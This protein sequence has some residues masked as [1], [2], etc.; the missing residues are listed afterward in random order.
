[1]YAAIQAGNYEVAKDMEA[2]KAEAMKETERN[3]RV[4]FALQEIAN[5]EHIVAT[6]QELLEAMANMA[7]QAK[8]KNLKNFIRK[9][10]REG[11]VQGIRLSV[12]TSKVIDLLARNAKVTIQG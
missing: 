3:L 4:Y 10:Y 5:K 9:M 12:I 8:E 7:Q 6:E 2:L 11:R 1:M